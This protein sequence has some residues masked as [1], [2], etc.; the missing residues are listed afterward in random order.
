MV[1]RTSFRVS[2][3]LEHI[4]RGEA[5]AQ[6]PSAVSASRRCFFGSIKSA[7]RSGFV[8]LIC[9]V[10]PVREHSRCLIMVRCCSFS[11]CLSPCPYLL[12]AVFRYFWG[13][14]SHPHPRRRSHSLKALSG[15][16]C[17][18]ILAMRMSRDNVN[19]VGE[20]RPDLQISGKKRH[21]SAATTTAGFRSHVTHVDPQWM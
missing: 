18:I 4:F 15:T 13:A 10:Y 1:K 6:V 2:S 14:P 5:G 19:S 9:F 16:T 3:I 11:M 7:V 17:V 12:K 20:I 8:D 21:Q